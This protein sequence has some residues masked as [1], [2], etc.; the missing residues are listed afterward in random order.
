M[1][2]ITERALCL[3]GESQ[4]MCGELPGAVAQQQAARPVA[5]GGALL[6]VPGV[7]ALAV[8][9]DLRARSPEVG[10]LALSHAELP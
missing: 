6:E 4:A 5:Q 3:T 8:A 9:A 1:V 7:P 2:V 10:G